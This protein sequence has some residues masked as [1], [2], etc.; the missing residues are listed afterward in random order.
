MAAYQEFGYN[1]LPECTVFKITIFARNRVGHKS[2]MISLKMAN[3]RH[4]QGEKIHVVY[5][6]E[7]VRR[8]LHRFHVIKEPHSD[9]FSTTAISV[10]KIQNFP[11]KIHSN[12]K[13]KGKRT[14]ISIYSG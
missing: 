9:P 10:L 2:Q 8:V 13:S 4:I 6:Y 3:S 11:N 5:I 7:S 12:S 14:L 1:S